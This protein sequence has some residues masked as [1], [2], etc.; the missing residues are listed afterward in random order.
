VIAC[1]ICGDEPPLCDA[2]VDDKFSYMCG[3]AAA[4]GYGWGQEVATKLG[5]RTNRL[6]PWP[7]FEGKARAIARRKVADLTADERLLERLARAC[8]ADARRRYERLRVELAPPAGAP[9]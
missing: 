6:P 3:T 1:L 5:G 8:W 4:R 2:C 9:R 7:D